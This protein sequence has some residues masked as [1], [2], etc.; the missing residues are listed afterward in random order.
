MNK[1]L[2]DFTVTHVEL[3]ESS[4][5]SPYIKIN[6][7]GPEG[8]EDAYC[9]YKID[10][11]LQLLS[12][13]ETV[14]IDGYRKPSGSS[15]LISVSSIRKNL[16]DLYHEYSDKY[17][18]IIKHITKPECRDL[19]MHIS[20]EHDIMHSFMS[21]PASLKEHHAYICGLMVHTVDAMEMG[22]KLSKSPNLKNE[23]DKSTLV[24]GLF[25]HDI[26]KTLCYT[27]DGFDL[28]MTDRCVTIGHV[29]LGYELLLR[30]CYSFGRFPIEL[31]DKLANIILSHHNNSRVKPNSVEAKIV[32]HI[33]SLSA[34][35][36]SME[37][38]YG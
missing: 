3:K 18:K 25:L 31:R 5:G 36:G 30:K 20:D 13:Y 22:V 33:D 24:L 12:K 14:S 10:E 19:F 1:Y 15:T 2:G 16:N 32:R 6:V 7:S 9:Y 8:N 28:G 34:G 35:L 27:V 23:I 17:F 26:G 11:H 29:S 4:A 37:V 21:V 38:C